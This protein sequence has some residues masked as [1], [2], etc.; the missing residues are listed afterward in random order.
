MVWLEK[1][2]AADVASDEDQCFPKHYKQ[3]QGAKLQPTFWQFT[4]KTH[5]AEQPLYNIVCFSVD[6]ESDGEV[7]VF[8]RPANKGKV[9]LYHL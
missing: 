8:S 9:R 4:C 6:L 2:K 3:H 5:T 1:K 7:R